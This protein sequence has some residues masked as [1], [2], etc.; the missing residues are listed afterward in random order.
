M[1]KLNEYINLLGGDKSSL[2]SEI[3]K[4]S[5]KNSFIDILKKITLSTD[6]KVV[7]QVYSDYLFNPPTQEIDRLL[8]L[9][10]ND[11]E[12]QQKIGDDSRQFFV[13]LLT[14]TSAS[15]P[16]ATSVATPA[17]TSVATSVVTPAATPVAT[18]AATLAAQA[19]QAAYAQAQQAQAQ[20]LIQQRVAQQMASRNAQPVVS[21]PA[22]ANDYYSSGEPEITT[23]KVLVYKNEFNK[24]DIL[25]SSG[26]ASRSH[27]IKSIL[28]TIK[29][30]S[31]SKKCIVSCGRI[32]ITSL[33][34]KD[35]YQTLGS[36][37]LK[38]DSVELYLI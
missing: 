10:G 3:N 7:A 5:E 30:A 9:I 2:I 37:H 27:T 11:T 12:F 32:F 8:V 22:Q 25:L 4:S 26:S 34:P 19:A 21:V 14:A 18:S 38:Y 23:F 6:S 13:D 17:A 16:A 35:Y 24:G 1:N 15:T 20:L 28:D 36:L 33:E 29:G 31:N